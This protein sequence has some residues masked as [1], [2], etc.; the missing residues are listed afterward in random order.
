MT[1]QTSQRIAFA[2]LTFLISI[3]LYTG[4]DA[5]TAQMQFVERVPWIPTF[6]IEYYLGVDGLSLP[7]VMMVTV[8]T[9]MAS[10]LLGSRTNTRSC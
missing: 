10:P 7:L 4:F 9:F 1:R 5:G 2:V 6:Q 8:V 3:P